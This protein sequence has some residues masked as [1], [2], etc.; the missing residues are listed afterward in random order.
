MKSERA[1][2]ME[3]TAKCKQMQSNA[4]NIKTKAGNT[5]PW[6]PAILHS[7]ELSEKEPDRRKALKHMTLKKNRLESGLLSPWHSPRVNI[8]LSAIREHT[9]RFKANTAIFWQ[10]RSRNKLTF[11]ACSLNQIPSE[12]PAWS[13][14]EPPTKEIQQRKQTQSGQYKPLTDC[15]FFTVWS[16]WTL[17]TV[18]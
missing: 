12:P 9:R 8:S 18:F 4:N 11:T 1:A 5:A 3:N 16:W 7:L 10:Y 2:D 6:P 14:R 17:K 15:T 13:R